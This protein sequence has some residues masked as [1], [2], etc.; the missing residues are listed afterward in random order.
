MDAAGMWKVLST[1]YGIRTMDDLKNA[2][3]N[4]KGID[5]GIFTDGVFTKGGSSYDTEGVPGEAERRASA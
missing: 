3:R 1:E 2:L 4:C 5:I